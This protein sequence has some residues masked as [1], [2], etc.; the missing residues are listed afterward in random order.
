[1][2]GFHIVLFFFFLRASVSDNF[3]F[4]K[5]LLF[6]VLKKIINEK[7]EKTFRWNRNITLDSRERRSGE[8]LFSVKKHLSSLVTHIV[9]EFSDGRNENLRITQSLYAAK[10][11]FFL[12]KKIRS[13]APEAW[14]YVYV[15]TCR[16][17]EDVV[18]CDNG[19]KIRAVENFL[20]CFERRRRRATLYRRFSFAAVRL[21][22]NHE[23]TLC[24][25]WNDFAR[26][27]LIDVSRS[28]NCL[29]DYSPITDK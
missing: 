24:A 6:S 17:D 14:I 25:R 18:G 22:E 12:A 23:R 15:H 5:K 27:A 10:S 19:N 7:E 29:F 1:M 26:R 11:E 2:P 8:K 21:Y 28:N 9:G 4:W 13:Y 16:V 3:L 20:T